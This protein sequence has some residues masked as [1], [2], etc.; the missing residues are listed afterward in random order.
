MGGMSA[1]T[2]TSKSL[3]RRLAA[4]GPAEADWQDFFARYDPLLERYVRDC[5]GAWG[6]G[7]DPQFIDEVLLDIRYNLFCRLTQF[8]Q[9]RRFRTW[10]YRVVKNAII[11]RLR[12]ARSYRRAI[13]R[14]EDQARSPVRRGRAASQ[15]ADEGGG[16]VVAGEAGEPDADW[17][18]RHGRAAMDEVLA[19]V[20]ARVA[21]RNPAQWQSFERCKL[22][23]R[24]AK[25]VATELGIDVNLVY[26]NVN[27]VLA[28]VHKRLL[29]S[30]RERMETLQAA[31]CRPEPAAARAFDEAADEE[32]D[33]HW[34]ALYHETVFQAAVAEVER[35]CAGERADDFAC[36]RRT[37]VERQTAEVVARELGRSA[38]QVYQAAL[39]VYRAV[40]QLCLLEFEEPLSHA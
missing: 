37:L 40:E 24:P 12:R 27:R 29:E 18:A 38:N 23:D 8:D 39:Q 32:P 34:N 17:F 11:D 6:A 26:Q 3:L 36:F 5:A 15:A 19:V 16:G 9:G 20:R 4:G 14:L 28:E 2:T 22:R 13:D 31:G 30:C 1:G 10:L 33:A 7:R 25:E 21:A 35:R